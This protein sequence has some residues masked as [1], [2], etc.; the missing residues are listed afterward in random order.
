MRID[1]LALATGRG[2]V[3]GRLPIGDVVDRATALLRAGVRAVA[4]DDVTA[5]LLG[6]QFVVGGD[7]RG[8]ELFVERPPIDAPRT[9]LGRP[10][11]FVGRERELA[12]LDGLIDECVAESV[13]R[14]VLV[15]APEGLGKS[16][17]IANNDTE[18]GRAQNRRVELIPKP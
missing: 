3:A 6:P 7:E 16:R 1:A 18:A 10:T 4:I 11:P 2:V 13:A 5:G 15:T 12:S 14:A 9:V 8:L 17:P